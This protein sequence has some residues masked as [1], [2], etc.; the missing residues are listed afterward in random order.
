MNIKSIIKSNKKNNGFFKRNFSLLKN[1]ENR[2]ELTTIRNKSYNLDNLYFGYLG[3]IRKI[4]DNK[5]KFEQLSNNPISVAYK[6]N[7]E[8]VEYFDD[9]I[10]RREEFTDCFN[11][12]KYYSYFTDFTQINDG[13]LVFAPLLLLAYYLPFENRVRNQI[14][15][16]ELLDVLEYFNHCLG[17]V[18]FNLEFDELYKNKK[19]PFKIHYPDKIEFKYNKPNSQD[20][21]T[22]SSNYKKVLEK[23]K[24]KDILDI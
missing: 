22:D 15:E 3:I 24:I 4:D 8:T 11:S 2:F 18:N 10:I 23:H 12:R 9:E 14:S 6:S 7:I 5:F 13:E 19:G 21:V 17:R 20:T 16:F 1:K